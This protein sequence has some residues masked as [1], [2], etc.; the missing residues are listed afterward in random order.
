MKTP[1]VPAELVLS[2]PEPWGAEL[3]YA[4]GARLTLGVLTELLRE[5]HKNV[6]LSA[7][8]IGQSAGLAGPELSA[9]CRAAL[10]RG[11]ILAVLSTG[12]GLESLR[13]WR[14]QF[15][16]LAAQIEFYQPAANV[17]DARQLGSHAK[18]CPQRRRGGLH[19]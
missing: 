3:A 16:S 10:E 6:V 18:F 11:V 17:A 7:P 5:S 8:Y 19:R 1:D 4:T 13:G 15:A 2:V 12:E 14:R 9:A